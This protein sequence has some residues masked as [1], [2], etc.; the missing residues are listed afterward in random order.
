VF[1]NVSKESVASIFR[2]VKSNYKQAEPL[3][4]TY[5][6]DGVTTHKTEEGETGEEQCQ[7]NAHHFL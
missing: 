6:T 1:I 4:P 5:Y 7:G 2:A 3:V